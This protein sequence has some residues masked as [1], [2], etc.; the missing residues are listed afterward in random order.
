MKEL[1]RLIG[2]ELLRSLSVTILAISFRN[3]V[4]TSHEKIILLELQFD[5]V[6]CSSTSKGVKVNYSQLVPE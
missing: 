1:S 4:P 2:N 6:F 3:V 5:F